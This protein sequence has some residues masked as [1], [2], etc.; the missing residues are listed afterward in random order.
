M[1]SERGPEDE[2][3]VCPRCRG[4]LRWESTTVACGTCGS[5]YPIVAG[6]PDFRLGGRDEGERE[7]EYARVRALSAD[8]ERL[9]AE[10]LL[11]RFFSSRTWSSGRE[12]RART[13]QIL[14]GTV[15]LS[16]EL[17]GWLSPC[18]QGEGP[19]LDLGCG[20]GQLLVAL[21]R[22]DRVGIGVD[23]SLDLL[24]IAR[25]LLRQNG[26]S[27]V[28]AA[29]Q[30]EAL[31]LKDDV[32]HSVVSLDVIEHV[33]DP[34]P[35]LREIDRVLEAKGAVALTTPNRFS[36]AAEPHVSVWGVG[37]L[38]RRYQRWYAESR[39]GIPYTGVR[40]L[41]QGEL[42]SLLCSHTRLVPEISV[43]PIPPEDIAR[44]P[45]RRARLARIYNRLLRWAVARSLLRRVAPFYR[46]LAFGPDHP[47]R[48]AGYEAPSS[49]NASKL[50]R[51]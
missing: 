48:D 11:L 51:T 6:L 32:V 8:A 4:A 5:D 42:R 3:L 2:I 22:A 36:L 47:Q 41:S 16:R 28:L 43:P 21:G 15:R 49:K 23:L 31:P 12:A 17:D 35:Y 40:L 18:L 27:G 29:G 44:F 19:I 37:W 33:D 34:V 10:A 30:A 14:D 24:V 25:A 9:S 1:R 20:A 39:S 45:V 13:R 50:S 38:P 46:V 7:R 26:C